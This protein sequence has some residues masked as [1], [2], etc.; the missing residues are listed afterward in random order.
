[1]FKDNW[2]IDIIN[3]FK[4]WGCIIFGIVPS[5]ANAEPE[6]ETENNETP[7]LT[8]CG[9]PMVYSHTCAEGCCDTY[10]CPI[11]NITVRIEYDG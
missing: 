3:F 5:N 10:R 9:V 4:Y 11:C 2:K 6:P 7:R 8:C 1:M